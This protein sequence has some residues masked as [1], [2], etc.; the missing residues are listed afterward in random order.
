MSDFK[1]DEGPL[2]FYLS[3]IAFLLH[4]RPRVSSGR[5]STF[6]VLFF[7]ALAGSSKALDGNYTVSITTYFLWLRLE[8]LL[9]AMLSFE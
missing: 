9:R 4:E 3:S 6:D 5:A 8:E 1:F 7:R 2:S